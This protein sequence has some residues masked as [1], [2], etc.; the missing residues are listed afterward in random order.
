MTLLL[1]FV[2]VV[3]VCWQLLLLLLLLA[4]LLSITVDA[5]DEGGA[6]LSVN[7]FNSTAA[8]ETEGAAIMAGVCDADIRGQS[9]VLD[10]LGRCR[11]ATDVDTSGANTAS[12]LS[13]VELTHLLP[14]TL[15]L[16]LLVVE[17]VVVAGAVMNDG[18]TPVPQW[19]GVARCVV[20]VARSGTTEL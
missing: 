14:P 15:L 7:P 19:D 9:A 10:D 2:T 5:A 16:L 3:E 20:S 18:F 4:V 1:L 13:I 12:R 6:K 11:G 8:G 17:V